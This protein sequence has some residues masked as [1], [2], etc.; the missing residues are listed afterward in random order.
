MSLRIFETDPEAKPKKRDRFSSDLTFNLKSGIQVNKAPMALENWGFTTGDPEVADEIAERFGGEIEEL[1]VDKG[2]DLR[3]LSTVN[4]LNVLVSGVDALRSRMVLFGVQ[5][6]IHECDGMF[7]LSEEDK[8]QP[9]GCPAKLEDRKALAAKGRGPKPSIELK[10]LLQDAPEMGFGRFRTGSWSL[11][12]ELA[13]VE[14]ALTDA[15]ERAN[16]GPVL[17][18]LKLEKVEY[19]TR[20]GK[21][22]AYMR[23]VIDVVGPAAQ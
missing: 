13:D 9:C 5:G 23:P 22:V 7:F 3:V 15:A 11:V 20:T 19:T 12:K 2:D 1:D 18:N 17:V 8:G 16:G 4:T 10:F 6:I 14:D 21:D